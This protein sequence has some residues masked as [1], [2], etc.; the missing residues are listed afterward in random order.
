[1][2]CR[3]TAGITSDQGEDEDEEAGGED[4]EVPIS[5]D[6]IFMSRFFAVQEASTST[7]PKTTAKPQ[8]AALA[9]QATDIGGPVRMPLE[10]R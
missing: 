3:L 10:L 6:D 1:M 9:S 7:G 8:R 2:N 5:M 4:K